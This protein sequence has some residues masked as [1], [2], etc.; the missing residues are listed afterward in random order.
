MKII[1]K[2]GTKNQRLNMQLNP[3]FL[4]FQKTEN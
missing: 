2:Y 1:L 4:K 3:F